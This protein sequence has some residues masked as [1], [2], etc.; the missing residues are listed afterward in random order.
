MKRKLPKPPNVSSLESVYDELELRVILPWLGIPHEQ[1]YDHVD[2]WGL[3]EPP[4]IVE[5]EQSGQM[6]GHSISRPIFPAQVESQ[7]VDHPVAANGVARL[8]LCGE[9]KCMPKWRKVQVDI[10]AECWGPGMSRR[11]AD[12]HR[13]PIAAPCRAAAVADPMREGSYLVGY[14]PGFD[15]YVIVWW[16][17]LDPTGEA[18]PLA[19]AWFP[20]GE[21]IGEA[22]EELIGAFRTSGA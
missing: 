1:I 11:A 10:L 4:E 3:A 13:E 17:P 5:S 14:L 22:C 21:D 19:I 18:W 8:V 20:Y 9:S 7:W 12:V 2:L 16:N 15:I 6:F